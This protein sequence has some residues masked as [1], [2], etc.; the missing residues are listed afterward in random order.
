M[1]EGAGRMINRRGPG[2]EEEYSLP[3][4]AGKPILLGVTRKLSVGDSK[5]ADPKGETLSGLDEPYEL[6]SEL[7]PAKR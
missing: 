7:V 6:R 1:H 3:A 2:Q 4:I 5:D